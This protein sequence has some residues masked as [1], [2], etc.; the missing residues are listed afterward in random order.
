MPSRATTGRTPLFAYGY[1]DVMPLRDGQMEVQRQYIR[2]N[3]RSR[4]LRSSN[5]DWL[6]AKRLSV[7]TA[8]SLSALKGYLQKECSPSQFSDTAWQ[9]LQSRLLTINQP[10][11]STAPTASGQPI[12][13]TAPTANG[14]PNTTKPMVACDSYGNR[15]L[16]ERRLLPVVCH[17]KDASLLAQQKVRCLEAARAGAVLVSARIAKGEQTIIDEAISQSLPVILIEDNGFAQVY[18]P[19]DLRIDLCA[20]SRLLL[21]TPWQH[22]YRERDVNIDVVMCKAMNC[23]VQALC[24][25]KDSWWKNP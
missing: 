21:L 1:V 15:Q 20:E 6:Q 19:S 24:K 17:R 23:V 4:L 3:P 5:R 8:L 7:P 12:P 9:N 16:L 10:T 13:T 11:T 14:Q 2:N 18:H 25:T 22:H